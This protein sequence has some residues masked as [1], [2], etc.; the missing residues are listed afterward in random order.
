MASFRRLA[1]GA[2]VLALVDCGAARSPGLA[3]RLD[4]LL[5]GEEA[6]G[7]AGSILVARGPGIVLDRGYGWVD[8]A[9][10]NRVTP[11]TRFWIASVSKQFT[12]AA[13]LTLAD[14]R[15]LSVDDPIGRHLPGVPEDKRGTTLHHLLTH[16]SGMRQRYAAD[17]IVDRDAALRALLAELLASPPGRQF[18]YSNDAYNL[19]AIV[20]EVVSGEPF[21]RFVQ[22]RVLEPAGLTETGFWAQPGHESVAEISGPVDAQVRGPN[23]GFRGATGMFST[24]RDLHRWHLALRAKRVLSD[25]SRRRLLEPQVTISDGA[26]AYGWFRTTGVGG[27]PTLWTRG[28]E[29]F[30]HNAILMTYPGEE[31]VIVAASNAGDRN[32][33]AVT[34]TLADEMAAILFGAGDA[35][36]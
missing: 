25:E 1:M 36:R 6:S 18:A 9:R 23:W 34:R 3:R 16:T 19:L 20:V 26:A 13:I 21:E 17:G 12:A 15:R 29:G 27:R 35:P 28:T 22:R 11:R 31:V 14:E 30:G 33:V 4:A 2:L 5:V 7:F 24:T 32:G 8:R 10:T